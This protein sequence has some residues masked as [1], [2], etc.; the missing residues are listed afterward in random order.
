MSEDSKDRFGTDAALKA[1]IASHAK[2]NPF[3]RLG[4]YVPTREE[5]AEMAAP[6]LM[7]LLDMWMWESPSELIPTDDQIQEVRDILLQRGD[8]GS[9]G[10]QAIIEL[11]NDFLP[12]Q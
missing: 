12:G 7:D 5:V 1:A 9:G 11:C 3:V 4:M 6:Q 10:V 8:A 2:E